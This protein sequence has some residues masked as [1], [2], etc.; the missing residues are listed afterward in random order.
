[1]QNTQTICLVIL[2]T[3]AVGFSLAFL[4]TVLLPFVV[5]VFIY[6]GCQPILKFL[7]SRLK[8][9]RTIAFAT[10]FLTG[11]LM[12][13]SFAVLVWVSMNDLSQNIGAYE[14]RLDHIAEWLAKRIPDSEDKRSGGSEIANDPDSSNPNAENVENFSNESTDARDAATTTQ[15]LHELLEYSSNHI[16][17]QLLNMLG[18]LSSLFSYGVLILIFV[19]FLLQADKQIGGHS[20]ASNVSNNSDGEAEES[21]DNIFV[22]IE[23]QIRKYLVMKTVIS[24]LTGLVFGFVL[25]LFGVPLA[26][27][28][29]FLAILLNFIPNIGPLISMMLPVPF[30]L[31]NSA[32]SPTLAILCFVLCGTIQFVS[33][34]IIETRVMGK[35]FD[36]S[37]AFLLLALMFFG[38]IWGIV[39]MFLAT[40]IVSIVKI[41]L[42]QYKMGQPVAELMAGR[43]SRSDSRNI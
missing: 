26:I 21:I 15:A 31:L 30:L 29:G 7:E 8:L 10:T 36:V 35:S 41:V 43:L 19:F 18:S 38:L 28:F 5:A 34:N 22:E 37:P 12:L 17:A 40:P 9:P 42:S 32:M 39:G 4:K 1:M 16:K 25:W 20:A 6:I 23:E 33:G 14:K 3:I 24:V 13:V 2:A 11:L 27:L